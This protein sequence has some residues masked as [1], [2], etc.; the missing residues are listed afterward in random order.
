VD[1]WPPIAAANNAAWCDLVCRTHGIEAELDAVAWTSRSRTPPLYPDAV[2]LV[3]D[4]EIPDLLAR[5]DDSPGCS[6]KDS[7]ASLDLARYGFRALFDA[8]WIVRA[9]TATDLIT[10][11]P[12]WTVV[13]DVDA[14]AAWEAA[15]RAH[16]G[17]S[18]VLRAELLHN[19]AVTVVAAQVNDR[20]VGGAALHRGAAVVGISNFF[21]DDEI[22]SVSWRGCL[23]TASALLPGETLVGYETDDALETAARHGFHPVGP[24]RVWLR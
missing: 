5:I 2:T 6:I 24:L 15:W 21:V 4:V 13:R 22:A 17:Q 8:Q 9:P 12:Q 23:A 3:A 11:D 7:F 1:S 14:F 19:P 10:A 16:H 20:I 18:A